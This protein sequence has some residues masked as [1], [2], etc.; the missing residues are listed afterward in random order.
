MRKIF[1]TRRRTLLPANSSLPV[2]TG[3]DPERC[4]LLGVEN[5]GKPHELP[6]A[7][8]LEELAQLVVTA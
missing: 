7:M 1:F 4:F 3:Q 6:L 5:G 2:R 8:S